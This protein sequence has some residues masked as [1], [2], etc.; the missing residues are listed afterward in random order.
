MSNPLAYLAL[1]ATLSLTPV[2]AEAAC[3][4]EFK[5][6]SDNPLA[7]YY[8]V[9]RIKGPCTVENATAQLQQR[10]ARRGLTLLKVLSV[11]RD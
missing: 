10:L 5:A 8:D 4:A 11:Q 2:W 9:A 3:F 7:L 1:A 6:K